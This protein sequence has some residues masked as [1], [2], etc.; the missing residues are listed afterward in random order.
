MRSAS[1]GSTG[2]LGHMWSRWSTASLTAVSC[3][4]ALLGSG[5]KSVVTNIF[6]LNPYTLW[7]QM[8]VFMGKVCL[9]LRLVFTHRAWKRYSGIKSSRCCSQKRRSRRILLTDFYHGGI[10]DLAYSPGRAFCPGMKNPWRIW[11]GILFAHLSPRK[12]WA[13]LPSPKKGYQFLW[14][15][16]FLP[17][18][19]PVFSFFVPH[20]I[21]PFL[22]PIW[23]SLVHLHRPF[24][25]PL[26][27]VY[28][29]IKILVSIAEQVII[30]LSA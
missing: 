7:V 28:T 2:S 5:V 10:P 19:V 18:I 23:R 13:G 27:Q 22:L 3:I 8:D 1:P 21:L 4:T 20:P 15:S 30:R 12:G 9:G 29:F 6:G 11:F 16:L 26:F 24:L 14:L 25:Y 17:L